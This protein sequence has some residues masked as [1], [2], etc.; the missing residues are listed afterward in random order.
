M[1]D[2]KPETW[3]LRPSHSSYITHALCMTLADLLHEEGGD[4]SRRTYLKACGVATAAEAFSQE[5]SHWF[6]SRMGEEQEMLEEL[7]SN[8]LRDVTKD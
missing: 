7:E 8:S 2:E 6:G 3:P 4:M 5:V 1:S